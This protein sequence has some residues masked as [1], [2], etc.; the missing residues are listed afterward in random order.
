MIED[1]GQLIFLIWALVALVSLSGLYPATKLL[2]STKPS[3]KNSFRIVAGLAA[4]GPLAIL[5]FERL[6]AQ[7]FHVNDASG[8][9]NMPISIDELPALYALSAAVAALLLWLLFAWHRRT[10]A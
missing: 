8:L 4:A 3:A 5:A 2:E 6:Q 7:T 10:A 9:Q 1:I